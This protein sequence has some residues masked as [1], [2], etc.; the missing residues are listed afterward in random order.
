MI[1]KK[2]PYRPGDAVAHP[3][4]KQRGL[5]AEVNRD[6]V[7][8]KVIGVAGPGGTAVFRKFHYSKMVLLATRQQILDGWAELQR[9]KAAPPEAAASIEG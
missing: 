7:R 8:F 9:K 6:W 1:S 5:V 4:S 2:N 3:S